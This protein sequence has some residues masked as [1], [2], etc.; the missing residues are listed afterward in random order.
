MYWKM[1]HTLSDSIKCLHIELSDNFISDFFTA[2]FCSDLFDM[3]NLNDE[4]MN[5]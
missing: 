5:L 2:L 4:L 1:S 3:F